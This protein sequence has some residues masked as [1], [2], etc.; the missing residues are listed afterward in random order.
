MVST[1]WIS[2]STVAFLV[3]V[4][5]AF[6]TVFFHGAVWAISGLVGCLSI[7][8]LW[9]MYRSTK[10]ISMNL[11]KHP[12]YTLEKS[13]ATFNTVLGM[14]YHFFALS[15]SVTKIAIGE[16]P[17]NSV[18]SLSSIIPDVMQWP[19]TIA[20]LKFQVDFD[21]ELNFFPVLALML[22]WYLV[23]SWVCYAVATLEKGALKR[24][25][26]FV[27]EDFFEKLPLAGLITDFTTKTF[28][29]TIY[30]KLIE[31][32]VCSTPAPLP[33]SNSTATVATMAVNDDEV[34]W[35]HTHRLY[36]SITLGLLIFLVPTAT[37]IG[38]QFMESKSDTETVYG[39][40][41]SKATSVR[42]TQSY[43]LWQI[44]VDM[45]IGTA[46]VTFPESSVVR[47]AIVVLCNLLMAFYI[48]VKS[49]CQHLWSINHW[50]KASYIG[51]VVL[52]IYTFLNGQGWL[53]EDIIRYSWMFVWVGLILVFGFR[54]FCRSKRI[55]I[56]FNY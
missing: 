27:T 28:F 37:V 4:G 3:V 38:T 10:D 12:K 49:P 2:L 18:F 29:I 40:F 23:A 44:G 46:T 7:Y 39:C 45:A 30:Q 17:Q 48:H 16:L 22:C 33:H 47:L 26:P 52:S 25:F 1:K 53:Q 15:A 14:V 42:W 43:Q 20:L 6:C 50:T 35:G 34:C 24:R 31:M 21:F 32:L 9:A 36:A 8:M 19:L 13:K 55:I 5:L 11:V 56:R 51:V 41:K 54:H